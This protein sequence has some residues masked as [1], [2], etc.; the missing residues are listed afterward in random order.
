MLPGMMPVD[1]LNGKGQAR[2]RHPTST[3]YTLSAEGWPQYMDGWEITGP[4]A[5]LLVHGGPETPVQ[6]SMRP[7]RRSESQFPRVCFNTPWNLVVHFRY[8]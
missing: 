1:V 7:I 2:S 6:T 4:K 5:P 8:R 3:H